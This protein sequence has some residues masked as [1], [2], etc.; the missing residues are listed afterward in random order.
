M[1]VPLISVSTAPGRSTDS[2]CR[3]LRPRGSNRFWCQAEGHGRGAA[4][5]VAAATAIAPAIEKLLPILCFFYMFGTSPHRRHTKECSAGRGRRGRQGVTR[6]ERVANHPDWM[7]VTARI[8]QHSSHT[9]PCTSA[10]CT[11]PPRGHAPYTPESDNASDP[12]A[13]GSGVQPATGND[14]TSRL[15][16]R[17]P[18]I[19]K[20]R[21]AGKKRSKSGTL[22]HRGGTRM[23]IR[24]LAQGGQTM[25]NGATT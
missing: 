20:V 1:L 6:N 21:E 11:Y 10:S 16:F 7:D 23:L 19:Q 14:P 4:L 12:E 9:P 5:M 17:S 15:L 22:S 2:R 13:I 25:S 3:C 8:A 24:T 18:K